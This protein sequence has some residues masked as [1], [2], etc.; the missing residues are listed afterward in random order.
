MNGIEHNI[1]TVK[2]TPIYWSVSSSLSQYGLKAQAEAGPSSWQ[3]WIGSGNMWNN[4]MI[5]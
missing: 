1:K 5:G 3:E 4:D 2:N